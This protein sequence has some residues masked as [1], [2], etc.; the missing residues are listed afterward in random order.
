MDNTHTHTPP[1][2]TLLSFSLVHTQFIVT[3]SHTRKWQ[4]EHAR[5]IH[6]RPPV[7]SFC[8]CMLMSCTEYCCLLSLMLLVCSCKWYPKRQSVFSNLT[9]RHTQR[10]ETNTRPKRERERYIERVRMNKTANKQ[11]E[12]NIFFFSNCKRLFS[13]S[14]F[15]SK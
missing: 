1:A 14:W 6:N 12:G 7:R 4:R 5:S 9:H 15:T 2:H 3:I 11:A 10:S 8:P 13:F